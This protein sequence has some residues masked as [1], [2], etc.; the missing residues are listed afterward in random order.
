MGFNHTH[1]EFCSLER[2]QEE[3][4]KIVKSTNTLLTTVK[5]KHLPKFKI[6]VDNNVNKNDD[7]GKNDN[8]GKEEINSE[9]KNEIESYKNN[10]QPHEKLNNDVDTNDKELPSLFSNKKLKKV[11]LLRH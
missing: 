5:E 4:N 2:A 10:S 9:V 3:F 1:E 8:L 7:V 6:I 11:E